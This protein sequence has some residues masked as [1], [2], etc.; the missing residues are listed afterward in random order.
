M[1]AQE[2]RWQKGPGG[3]CNW[4]FQAPTCRSPPARLSVLAHLTGA[5]LRA[6][7]VMVDF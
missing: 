5:N 7:L 1:I 4:A 6:Q 3:G 2:A